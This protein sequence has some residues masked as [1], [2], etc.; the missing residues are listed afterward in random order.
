MGNS[1]NFIE[2]N[3]LQVEYTQQ[4]NRVTALQSVNL[5]L[6]QG[7]I[8]VLIGPSGSGKST[9]LHV[10]AGMNSYYAGQVS[11]NSKPPSITSMSTALILQ[12][13]GLL[14]WKNVWS[15]VALGLDIRKVDPAMISEKVEAIL[16]SLGLANLAYRYPAQLSGGQRQRVAIARALALKPELLL[17]DEPFSSLDA[18][19]REELQE[20]LLELWQDSNMTILLVTHGIEEAA[21]LGQKIFAM[22]SL[23]GRIIGTVDNHL[24]GDINT[25]GKSEYYEL[26]SHLRSLLRGGDSC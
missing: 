10:L 9:L 24:A 2:V 26:C 4:S 16:K 25:R 15:N 11:I 23:P 18:L 1:K 20:L 19:T 8:G 22:S 12:D 7:K 14:P 13:Y 5:T 21:F 3:S 17:M 6:E